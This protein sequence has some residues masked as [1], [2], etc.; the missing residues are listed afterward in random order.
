MFVVASPPAPVFGTPGL[1]PV[2]PLVLVVLFV[3]FVPVL[4]V[5]LVPP[6][7]VESVPFMVLL[8]EPLVEPFK[9]LPVLPVP[10]VVLYV[11]VCACAESAMPTERPRMRAS[12]D[13][14]RRGFEFICF[15]ILLII[16]DLYLKA[17]GIFLAFLPSQYLIPDMA[18]IGRKKWPYSAISSSRPSANVSATEASLSSAAS[19]SA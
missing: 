10:F 8:L 12:V 2:V 18:R 9:L 7:P 14:L 16:V 1:V 6:T 19:S 17:D 4:L 13:R 15:C 3:L 5:L 11:P